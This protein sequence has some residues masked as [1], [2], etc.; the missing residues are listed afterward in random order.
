MLVALL[1][2][3]LPVVAGLSVPLIQLLWLARSAFFMRPVLDSDGGVVLFRL[4]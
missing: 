1:D 3:G 2:I 4:L